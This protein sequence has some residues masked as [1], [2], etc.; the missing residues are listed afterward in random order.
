MLTH[1]VKQI[2]RAVY[3][4]K[5][6]EYWYLEPLILAAFFDVHYGSDMFPT[7][8]GMQKEG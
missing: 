8:I 5:T 4:F 1:T 6:K 3:E 2:I 7:A